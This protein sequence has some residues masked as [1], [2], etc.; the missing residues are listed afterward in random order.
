MADDSLTP[1]R[2]TARKRSEPLHG[3][4]R[5]GNWRFVRKNLTLD[6]KNGRSTY[7]VDLETIRDSA[8]M[9]DWIFQFR[10]LA[11]ATD[12]DT[13]NLLAA[14]RDTLDPQANLCS[15]KISKTINPRKILAARLAGEA[16]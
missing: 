16:D 15:S 14:F 7:Y 12:E 5:W 2:K 10:T 1:G 13:A 8:S 6:W 9:L 4:Q 11:A 3:G